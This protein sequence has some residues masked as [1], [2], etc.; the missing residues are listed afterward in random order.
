MS[1][2]SQKLGMNL[3]NGITNDKSDYFIVAF[4]NGKNF[5]PALYLTIKRAS[6]EIC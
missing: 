5:K 1:R 2:I 3:L 4:L 6:G